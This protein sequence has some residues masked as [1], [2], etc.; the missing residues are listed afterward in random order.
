MVFFSLFTGGHIWG[1]SLKDIQVGWRGWSSKSQ[2][3]THE[4][5]FNCET[6][7]VAETGGGER[8]QEM[9]K[10]CGRGCS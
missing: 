9:A 3:R 10:F 8:G 7:N 4:L 1:A 5:I 2:M 6:S